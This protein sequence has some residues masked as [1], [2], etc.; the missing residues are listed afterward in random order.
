MMIIKPDQYLDSKLL[1][2]QKEETSYG[3]IYT[4]TNLIKKYDF[5]LKEEID[6]FS[7]IQIEGD[8]ELFNENT[9]PN[10]FNE[11]KYKLSQKNVGE[12]R[13]HSFEVKT[14]GLIIK[15]DN[16][17]LKYIKNEKLMPD[18]PY[19]YLFK[20]N[21]MTLLMLLSVF[22]KVLY[23]FDVE[24]KSKDK[25]IAVILFILYALSSSFIFLYYLIK[26]ILKIIDEKYELN[27]SSLDKLSI[28]II[29]ILMLNPFYIYNYTFTAVFLIG[30]LLNIKPNLDK[31]LSYL[32]FSLIILPLQIVFTNEINLLLFILIPLF[33]SINKLTFIP[34]FLISVLFPFLNLFEIFEN[35][36]NL[37]IAFFK[38]H[39]FSV[40][41]ANLSLFEALL[42]YLVILISFSF[43]RGKSVVY[44]CL[45]SVILF[46]SFNF[47]KSNM[48]KDEVVFL[49]VGQGD[50]SVI[51]KDNKVIVVDAFFGVKDY[52]K[53]R[54]IRRIDHLILT[55]NDYDH[56]AE[57]DDLIDSFSIGEIYLSGYQTYNIRF[58]SVTYINEENIIY[59][60]DINLEFLGPFID[61]KDDN[62]NSI[63]FKISVLN[64]EYLFTGDMDILAEKLY[65]QKYKNNLSADVLKV[66]HHGSI[67]S[68]SYDFIRFVNPSYAIV[69]VGRKNSYNLPSNEVIER[70][71]NLGVRVYLTSINGTIIFKDNEIMNFAP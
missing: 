40:Y 63:V 61:L 43:K 5:Y 12:I 66:A 2:T 20:L 50:S 55:H 24:E 32:Y 70:Y 1:I 30:F 34:L 53:S 33:R 49:D 3:F 59:L 37:I 16:I 7:I 26:F 21:S 65:I 13:V 38:D 62:A 57:I 45:I 10:G 28:Y 14:N 58:K 35:I 69:S 22:K 19:S 67:T 6:I 42:Y 18:N 8:I 64:N 27:L 71:Q 56:L 31:K 51:F 39:Q 60:E 52:L 4:G 11:K 44:A 68:S 29:V 46:T 54:G 15:S 23:F 48:F 17:F 47:Y 25:V 36:F 41:V 9:I